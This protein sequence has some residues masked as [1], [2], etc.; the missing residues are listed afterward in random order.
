MEWDLLE[1]VCAVSRETKDQRTGS[2]EQEYAGSVSEDNSSNSDVSENLTIVSVGSSSSQN[3]SVRTHGSHQ[4]RRSLSVT[5]FTVCQLSRTIQVIYAY[6]FSDI[7][8]QTK[9]GTTWN[10]FSKVRHPKCT[11]LLWWIQISP[12]TNQC[13]CIVGWIIQHG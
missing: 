3:M 8:F 13:V 7:T 9:R 6:G 4:V 12:V 2:Y 5:V 10:F 11:S 1:I